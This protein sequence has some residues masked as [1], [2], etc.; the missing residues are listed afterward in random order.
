M[1]SLI[2]FLC[3]FYP[4]QRDAFHSGGMVTMMF[5]SDGTREGESHL[6]RHSTS[7]WKRYRRCT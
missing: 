2:C 3:S 6:N 7:S 1:I 4:Q 5:F